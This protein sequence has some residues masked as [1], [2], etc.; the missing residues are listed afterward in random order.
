MVQIL[1]CL[2]DILACSKKTIKIGRLR[3]Y[4]VVLFLGQ[5]EEIEASFSKLAKHFEDD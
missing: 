5:D 3:R 1:G 4:A 2:L